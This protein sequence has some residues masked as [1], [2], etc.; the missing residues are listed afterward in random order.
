[1]K[2]LFSNTLHK[3]ISLTS[4]LF[5]APWISIEFSS[6]AA[7]PAFHDSDAPPLHESPNPKSEAQNSYTQD[8]FTQDVNLFI[9]ALLACKSLT[10]VSQVHAQAVVTG[11]AENLTLS[12]KFIYIYAQWRCLQDARK[13]FDR[14]NSRDAVSWS[15]MVGGYTKAGDHENCLRIFREIVRSGS[16]LDNYS[17]PSALRSCRHL[18]DLQMGREIHH[19]VLKTG[20]QRDLFVSAAL[21]DMYAKCGSLADA[22]KVFDKM[23]KRDL[24]S[25]TVMIM[26]YAEGNQASESMIL[27][28]RMKDEGVLPDKVTMVTVAFACAKLGAMHKAM[29]IHEY[30]L[31]RKFSLDVILGTATIDMYAKCGSIDMARDTFDS[32]PHRNVIS[33][34]AMI[35]AYGYHGHGHKALE[36]FPMMLQMG[37]RPNRITFLSILSACSHAG[38]VDEGWHY[39]NSM[40]IDYFVE[41]DVKHYT[42]MV[43]LLGRAGKLEEACD[44][45]GG[46]IIEPDEGL[47]GAVLGACRIHGNIAL[48]EEAANC[49]LNMGPRNPGYYVLLSNIYAKAG[50]WEDM[51]KIREMMGNRKLKK[52]PGWTWIEIDNKTHQFSVGDKTHPLSKEIYDKLQSLG[53]E[54]ERVGYVPDTNFVLH[55]VDEEM[56]V[57]ILYTHSEKLAIAYGL[58]S[59]TPGTTIRIMKNLRVCGDCHTFTKFL[60]KIEEREIIVRDGNRFHHFKDGLCSCGDYW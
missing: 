35:A 31:M 58:I 33:W 10:Q 17:T 32:M 8:E 2:L 30:I 19:L 49:L 27:F 51:A 20:L 45:I 59:T 60:S 54:M 14:M 26:A 46:M 25:W 53:V 4:S 28:D 38:L 16:A 9:S 6:A 40:R 24:V 34:S 18:K 1:M 37:I 41:P 5:Q 50:R 11:T 48:A 43:D 52:T 21:V 55:D 29:A 57:G 56:K 47:W 7:S 3:R 13:I 23:P 15:V 22:K 36:L 42:C 44:L 12:N 39:F